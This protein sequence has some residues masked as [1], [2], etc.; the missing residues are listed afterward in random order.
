MTVYHASVLCPEKFG[1]LSE[2]H[3]FTRFDGASFLRWTK[4]RQITMPSKAMPKPETQLTKAEQKKYVK[5]SPFETLAKHKA[6]V[7]KRIEEL[8]D[9]E[10][11]ILM[12]MSTTPTFPTGGGGAH[13][14]SRQVHINS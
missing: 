3:R 2:S 14:H 5:S 11:P 9:V 12:L 1:S 7:R 10:Q 4:K 8:R 13:D 6:A